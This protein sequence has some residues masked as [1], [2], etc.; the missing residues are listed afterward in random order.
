[1]G[2]VSAHWGG[3]ADPATLGKPL[4][5]DP[6]IGPPLTLRLQEDGELLVGGGS[7]FGGYHRDAAATAAV[8]SP[9]GLYRSGDAL[10]WSEQGELVFLDRVKDMRR[11]C[12]GERFPPQTIENHLRAS[13]F[14]R[15]AIVLG[16]ETRP[17]VAAL[18]N[19]DAQIVGRYLEA[20]HIGWGTFAELSQLPAVLEVIRGELAKVNRLLPPGSGLVRFANLPKELDADDAELTRSRKLKRDVI[21]SRYG[22]LIEMLY[23]GGD[24]CRLQVQVM[25]Q[26]GSVAQVAAC[27]KA[28]NVKEAVFS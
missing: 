28:G 5:V 12:T 26:D 10:H 14:I 17:F 3:P 15:D 23:A 21:E 7:G 22:A 4:L 9:E 16:D 2:L 6:S 19:I 27:V 20:R 24:E 1:M 11:L 18:I 8:L 25:Y 13:A